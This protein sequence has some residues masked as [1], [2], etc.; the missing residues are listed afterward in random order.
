[1]YDGCLPLVNS[2]AQ[3]TQLNC[4]K[5]LVNNDQLEMAREQVR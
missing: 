3:L 4:L 1:M 5:L 2:T